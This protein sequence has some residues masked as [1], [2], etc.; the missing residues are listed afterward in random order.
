MFQEK[1][2]TVFQCADQTNKDKF[3]DNFSYVIIDIYIN[4]YLF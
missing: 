4:I 3:N 1:N 2:Q